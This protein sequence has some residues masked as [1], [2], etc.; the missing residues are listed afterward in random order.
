MEADEGS[1][2]RAELGVPPAN[3]KILLIISIS[4]FSNRSNIPPSE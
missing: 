3:F 1:P 2:E 4:V